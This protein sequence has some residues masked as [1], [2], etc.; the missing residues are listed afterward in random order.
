MARKDD[1]LAGAKDEFDNVGASHAHLALSAIC[2]IIS[3][4]IHM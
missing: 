4:P 1:C 3:A 2:L